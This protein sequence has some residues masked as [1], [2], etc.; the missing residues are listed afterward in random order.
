MKVVKTNIDK[1]QTLPWLLCARLPTSTKE[2]HNLA[3]PGIELVLPLR[4]ERT[5]GKQQGSCESPLIQLFLHYLLHEH[6]S[7]IVAEAH[8]K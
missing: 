2:H 3:G 4:F 5:E 6:R 7:V 1:M 8:V